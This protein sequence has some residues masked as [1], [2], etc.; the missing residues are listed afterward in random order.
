MPLELTQGWLVTLSQ[1]EGVTLSQLTLFGKGSRR[2]L[3]R[4]AVGRMDFGCG[5]ADRKTASTPRSKP[6]DRLFRQYPG[7]SV[8]IW[9]VIPSFPSSHGALQKRLPPGLCSPRDHS[10][11]EIG[12][13]TPIL[14][15]SAA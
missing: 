12:R 14:G 2:L 11:R 4:Y 9:L 6:F 13:G 10:L 1:A 3:A 7:D 8:E 5:L 15:P